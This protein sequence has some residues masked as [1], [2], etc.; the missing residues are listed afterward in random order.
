MATGIAV[1]GQMAGRYGHMDW[2]DGPRWW[3]VV[4]MILVFLALVGVAVWAVIYATRHGSQQP[5]T[6]TTPPSS[7]PSARE[8]LDQRYARGE[9]DSAE[10]E[11]RKAK[12]A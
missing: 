10:Y 8:I 3:V 4:P 11:E 7:G 9:I 12:L 1:V 5:T 2:N 6:P